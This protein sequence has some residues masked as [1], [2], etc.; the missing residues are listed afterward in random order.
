MKCD[1]VAVNA[2][3]CKQ[4]RCLVAI[5]MIAKE[6]GRDGPELVDM[7]RELGEAGGMVQSLIQRQKE[8]GKPLFL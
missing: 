2:A 7:Q 1:L 4:I 8:D 5:R 3:L 6:V